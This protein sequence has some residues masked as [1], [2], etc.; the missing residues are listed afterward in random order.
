ME[1]KASVKASLSR[2]LSVRAS[3][4]ELRAKKILQCVTLSAI[5]SLANQPK[6]SC[7]PLHTIQFF[8]V[9]FL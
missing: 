3:V 9:L 5:H 1:R 2:K 4:R 7:L 6:S 8:Y